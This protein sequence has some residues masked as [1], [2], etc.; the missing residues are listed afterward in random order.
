[1]TIHHASLSR[2]GGVG[3]EGGNGCRLSRG[4]WMTGR[5]GKGGEVSLFLVCFLTFC[6]F[7]F[8][9]LWNTSA[10]SSTDYIVDTQLCKLRN[11]SRMCPIFTEFPNFMIGR[12]R[13]FYMY[14]LVK[15]LGQWLPWM[16]PGSTNLLWLFS[17]FRVFFFRFFARL[18]AFLWSLPL[19]SSYIVYLVCIDRLYWRRLATAL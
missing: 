4:R 3:G 5:T 1:M 17:S 7:L 2:R 19:T 9:K 12:S 16:L 15:D 14:F 10:V 8:I 11:M 13:V 18:L 6:F